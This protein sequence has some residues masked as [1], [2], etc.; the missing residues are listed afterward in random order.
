[1]PALLPLCL[2][3]VGIGAVLSAIDI[4]QHRLP[5]RIVLPM[6]PVL[7]VLLLTTGLITG[8]WP[9]LS[10]VGG[11]GLWLAAIGSV[12]LATSGRA[13]GLGDVKLAPLLGASLGWV[14]WD[15]ALTG[16][17]CCWLLGG[18]C[19]LALLALGRV[20]R[21]DAIAFGPFMILGTLAGI[22]LGVGT[23]ASAGM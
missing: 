15:A 4:R 3:W 21:T 19:A 9:L 12:W 8:R 10:C 5:D 20:R 23:W 2:L 11:A 13:M 16:L 17:V 1:M 6:Y 7:A 22:A 18:L 14:S